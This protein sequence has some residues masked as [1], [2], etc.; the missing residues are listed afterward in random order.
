M[1]VHNIPTMAHNAILSLEF[2]RTFSQILIIYYPRLSVSENSQIMH[3]GILIN[4]PYLLVESH[5]DTLFVLTEHGGHLGFFILSTR[6]HG[7]RE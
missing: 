4:I 7:W 2:P 5:R 6:I 1:H 3:C